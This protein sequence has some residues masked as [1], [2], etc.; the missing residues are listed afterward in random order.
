MT[1]SGAIK[2]QIEQ[3]AV[4]KGEAKYM[5]VGEVYFV[6]SSS[7]LGEFYIVVKVERKGWACNCRGFR[8]SAREDGACKHVD[9]AESI[10]K[11]RRRKVGKRSN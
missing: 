8:F 2:T 6:P 3:A 5:G 9:T 1:V 11:A 4:G 7:T 10:R